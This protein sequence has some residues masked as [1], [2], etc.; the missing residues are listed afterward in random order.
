MWSSATYVHRL[1]TAY[2]KHRDTGDRSA[3][4]RLERNRTGT[5]TLK[6]AIIIS[7]LGCREHTIGMKNEVWLVAERTICVSWLFQEMESRPRNR[8]VKHPGSYEVTTVVLLL[9]LSLKSN[10]AYIHTST[11]SSL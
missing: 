7:R 2:A 10:G 9:V 11:S 8:A 1:S 4:V 3:G 5:G 6:D